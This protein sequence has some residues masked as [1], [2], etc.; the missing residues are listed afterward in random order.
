MKTRIAAKSSKAAFRGMTLLE[1]MVVIAIIGIVATAVS[2]GVVGY[3]NKARVNATKSQIGTISNALQMYALD[4]DYPNTLTALT[5]G[6]GA[7]LKPKQLKDPWGQDFVYNYPAQDATREFDL[8]S[9][10]PDRRENTEDDI[11]ND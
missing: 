1:I 11:C 5:E 7:P 8:C 2:V 6:V 3:L 10:G 4:G 9:K